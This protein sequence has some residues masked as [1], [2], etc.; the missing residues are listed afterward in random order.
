MRVMFCGQTRV[1][2]AGQLLCFLLADS[3]SRQIGNVL[4]S[5]GVEIEHAAGCINVGNADDIQVVAYIS[6]NMRS[7]WLAGKTSP[8]T[9][10]T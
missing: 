7:S 9:S 2:M 3:A 4:D 8:T 10:N 6:R 5:R 1:R